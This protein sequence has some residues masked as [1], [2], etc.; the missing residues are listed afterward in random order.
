MRRTSTAWI[1]L[2]P[3]R[4]RQYSTLLAALEAGHRNRG[5]GHT[6]H[7]VAR[8]TAAIAGQSG[9]VLCTLPAGWLAIGCRL[10]LE[11]RGCILRTAGAGA[12]AGTTGLGTEPGPRRPPDVLRDRHATSYSTAKSGRHGADRNR[13]S[14]AR[15]PD[16]RNFMKTPERTTVVPVPASRRAPAE[17]PS[18]AVPVGADGA[19]N[20]YVP[21]IGGARAS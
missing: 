7:Q 9:M 3:G 14:A 19:G 6:G 16:H 11:E 18:I 13:L 8:G 10:L 1:R 17:N 20:L 21:G 4:R 2:A 5:I 12:R 15:D